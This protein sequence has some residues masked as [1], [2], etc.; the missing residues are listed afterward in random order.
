LKGGDIDPLEGG[1][2]YYTNKN[3]EKGCR[4]STD[5]SNNKNKATDCVCDNV[6]KPSINSGC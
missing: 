4:C 1:S 6:D 5:D 3:K 2:L